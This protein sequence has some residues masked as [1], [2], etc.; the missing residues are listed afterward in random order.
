MIRVRVADAA[1]CVEDRVLDIVCT[2]NLS[3]LAISESGTVVLPRRFSGRSLK[4]VEGEL[5]GRCLE[6]ADG[7]R[8]YLLAFL[9]LRM[10]LEELAKL[11]A[12]MCGGSVET[13]NG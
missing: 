4:E 8:S 5:C 6:V 9:T 13:P 10:G 11:V 12:A 3:A 1:K 7:V 2:C